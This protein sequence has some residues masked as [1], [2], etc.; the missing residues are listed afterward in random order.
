MTLYI[1]S[2]ELTHGRQEIDVTTS[3]DREQKF[4]LGSA[5]AEFEIRGLFTSMEDAKL[6]Y[7][8]IHDGEGMLDLFKVVA[9]C[10]WCGSLYPR[11]EL[12]CRRGCGGPRTERKKQ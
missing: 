12:R 5:R 2:V 7:E 1:R 4:I 6:L 11:K 9:A 3:G 10:E 8:L